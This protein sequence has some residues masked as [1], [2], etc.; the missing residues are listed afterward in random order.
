MPTHTFDGE[1]FTLIRTGKVSDVIAKQTKAGRWQYRVNGKII[2]SGMSP[3]KFVQEFWYGKL[4][5]DY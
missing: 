5:E 2:A 3:A 1:R 4:A